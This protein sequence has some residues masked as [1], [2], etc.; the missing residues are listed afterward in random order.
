MSNRP[1]IGRRSLVAALLTLMVARP[2]RAQTGEDTRLRLRRRD[3]FDTWQERN[4]QRRR[5][6]VDLSGESRVRGI[7]APS[8]P[9]APS[10]SG[11]MI[12]PNR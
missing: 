2:A 12:V 7:G 11:S 10:G 5:G 6:P 1:V 4:W 9:V 3:Q 8:R